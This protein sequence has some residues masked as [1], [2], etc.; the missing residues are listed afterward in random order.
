MLLL[1]AIASFSLVFVGAFAALSPVEDIVVREDPIWAAW[2][3]PGLAAFLLVEYVTLRALIVPR[4]ADY[5][6]FEIHEN[7]VDFYP[8]S[9]LGFTARPERESV[10]ISKFRGVAVRAPAGEGRG[11]EKFQ[12]VLVHPANGWTVPA[13]RFHREEDARRYAERLA[14]ALKLNFLT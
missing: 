6:R 9:R 10:T 1:R 12:V 4:F 5:G 3:A 7:K 14:D 8:L 11:A 13:A 2:L